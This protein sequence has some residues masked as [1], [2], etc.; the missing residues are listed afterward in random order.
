MQV[1]GSEPAL[2]QTATAMPPPQQHTTVSTPEQSTTVGVKLALSSPPSPGF[3]YLPPETGELLLCFHY[4]VCIMLRRG[5]STKLKPIVH[6][7]TLCKLTALLSTELQPLLCAPLQSFVCTLTKCTQCWCSVYKVDM[8]LVLG[9]PVATIS[10]Q[11]LAPL[12]PK[13]TIRLVGPDCDGSVSKA[14]G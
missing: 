7:A 8:I 1:A 13:L 12:Y 4:Q 14:E 6:I 9:K 5:A 11:L 3:S 10:L 2:I